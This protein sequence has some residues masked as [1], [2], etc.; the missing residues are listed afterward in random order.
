MWLLGTKLK[1]AK[2][3]NSLTQPRISSI[4]HKGAVE[5]V[6]GTVCPRGARTGVDQSAVLRINSTTMA[7]PHLWP[8]FLLFV[9]TITW[10]LSGL[11]NVRVLSV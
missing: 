5:D 6:E 1:S 2:P 10:T 3:I 8:H 7:V 9:K 4:R 11:N